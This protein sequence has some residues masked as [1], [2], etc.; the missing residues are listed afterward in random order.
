MLN[1]LTYQDIFGDIKRET[2]LFFLSVVAFLGITMPVTRFAV[3]EAEG[4][5]SAV[6]GVG[7]VGD[8]QL[9]FKGGGVSMPA[10][11]DAVG[12]TDSVWQNIIKKFHVQIAAVFGIFMLVALY[13]FGE[14][15]VKL[16]MSSDNP[17]GRSEIISGMIV[18][19]AATAALGA[20]SILFGFF[21]HLLLD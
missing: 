16:I 7:G 21:Y 8:L 9:Q 5:S 2:K 19:G 4:P 15:L 18:A 11:F 20:T 13:K 12:N 17:R 3:D 10:G 14:L 6:G 1:T